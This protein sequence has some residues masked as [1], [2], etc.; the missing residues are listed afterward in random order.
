MLAI[1]GLHIFA[2]CQNSTARG[3]KFIQNITKTQ[4]ISP[5]ETILRGIN[6][7]YESPLSFPTERALHTLQRVLAAWADEGYANMHQKWRAGGVKNLRT[8]SPKISVTIGIKS[9]DNLCHQYSVRLL[10]LH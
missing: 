8:V 10:L 7:H 3:D 2:A 5:G 6:K 9:L 1:R 4:L